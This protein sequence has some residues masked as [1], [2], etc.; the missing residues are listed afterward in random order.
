MHVMRLVQQRVP[1]L[2]TCSRMG[3]NQKSSPPASE[4]LAGAS[5]LRDALWHCLLTGRRPDL[6][7]HLEADGQITA[8]FDYLMVLQKAL[9]SLSRGNC[10]TP[11]QLKGYTAGV[12]K[13]LQSNFRHLIW[14][15]GLIASGDF[16]QRIDFMGELSDAFN[17]M[18]IELAE[19][20]AKLE[21]QKEHL[22]SL[23]EDLNREIAVRIAAEHDLRREEQRLR[24]LASID[25]LTG[26]AN[27]RHFF[28][29][30]KKELDR[31]RRSGQPCCLA[32]TDLDNFKKLNDNYGHK[33]GDTALRRIAKILTSGIRAY[34]IVGRYG[35][36]E[37]IL[38]F[39]GADKG[40]AC[41]T[42]QR[43][44]RAIAEAGISPPD[45]NPPVAISCGL[46]EVDTQ[47]EGENTLHN[48]ILRA[49][50]AMYSAKQQGG[51]RVDLARRTP[52]HPDQSEQPDQPEQ[53][54]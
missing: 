17:T 52:E 37:F 11:V 20:H 43:L 39:S 32:M 42:L 21:A 6:P 51:N 25:P 40:E 23:S 41:G 12:V 31:S 18:G 35:G 28:Y 50:A 9:S 29:L 7:P 13:M 48:A 54:L 45:M 49:D 53:S 10:S 38:L 5:E 1:T 14:K 44:I 4:A 46:T 34:D 24:K 27:R 19:A 36:D 47:G 30:A 8:L 3:A 22:A 16:S 26:I 15:A 33:Y 2:R